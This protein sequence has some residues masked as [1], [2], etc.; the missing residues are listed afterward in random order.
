MSPSNVGIHEKVQLAYTPST[1]PAQILERFEPGWTAI[2][3]CQA[4][5]FVDD[6]TGN[7]LFVLFEDGPGPRSEIQLDPHEVKP[8]DPLS[9]DA[10]AADPTG[11]GEG[12]QPLLD[13]KGAD[14][15]TKIFLR[16]RKEP[17]LVSGDFDDV[18]R[19]IEQTEADD[20]PKFTRVG[21]DGMLQ[22]DDI[23]INPQHVVSVQ[24]ERDYA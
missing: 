7:K 13:G 22:P 3:A 8:Y 17:V 6:D 21:R 2:Q 15:I 9:A 4:V 10:V 14:F 18:V 16:D 5:G 12:H 20:W 24:S 19:A 23:A 11:R 1:L